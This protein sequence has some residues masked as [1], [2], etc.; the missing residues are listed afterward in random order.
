VARDLAR[1]ADDNLNWKA[2]GKRVPWERRLETIR[3]EFPRARDADWVGIFQ[4]PDIFARILKDILKIDQLELGRAGPR[5]NLDHERGMRSWNEIQGDYS[6]L[7]FIDAFRIL[8]RNNSTRT[9]A[10]KTDIS[11][12]RVM[13]LLAGNDLP[14]MKDL[15]AIAQA[16]NKKPAYF[17]EYRAEY[18]LATIATRLHNE[19]ELTAAL[20]RKLVQQ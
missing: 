11:R 17:V 6:E 2:L 4:D 16:Y 3:E 18:I 1:F 10:R 14:S 9:I 20:Y 12:A 15:R 8:T 5:P 7:H 19:H 13:R